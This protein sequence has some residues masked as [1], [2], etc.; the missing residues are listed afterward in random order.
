MEQSSAKYC[1]TRVWQK[2]ALFKTAVAPPGVA[3]QGFAAV[4]T[5]CEGRFLQAGLWI[6][7]GAPNAGCNIVESLIVS[8]VLS[9]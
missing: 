9:Q 8:G 2:S 4:F 7:C 5:A 3:A 1:S 6:S